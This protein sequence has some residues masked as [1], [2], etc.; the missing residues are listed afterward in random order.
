MEKTAFE[1]VNNNDLKLTRILLITL[2][3]F[4]VIAGVYG[5]MNSNN[6]GNTRPFV[7]VVMGLLM[8]LNAGLLI[9]C[10]LGLGRHKIWYYR[11]TLLLLFANI[12]LSFADQFGLAD[13]V[14]L[15]FTITPFLI[16]ITRR[17][18]FVPVGMT[19]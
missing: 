15:A 12:V 6:H 3:G 19:R 13:L 9:L 14:V 17:R 18:Y 1:N 5:L 2:A 4:W 10:S 11:F 8:L 16:L 7:F